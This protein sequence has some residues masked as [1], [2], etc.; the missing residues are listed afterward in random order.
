MLLHIL[1]IIFMIL[2]L[3]GVIAWSW[4]WVT[5]PS[6]IALALWLL[7][8]IIGVCVGFVLEAKIQTRKFGPFVT[9]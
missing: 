1:T 4:W 8:F 6:L 7:L 2:K 3:F 5:F 9:V